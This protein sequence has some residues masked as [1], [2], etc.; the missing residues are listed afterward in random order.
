MDTPLVK[1]G[2]GHLDPEAPVPKLPLLAFA[3]LGIVF[4]DVG[5]SPLYTLKAIFSDT[6]V[7]VDATHASVLGVLSLIFWA[8][9]LVITIKYVTVVM[10]AQYEGEGGIFSMLASLQKVAV[11]RSSRWKSALVFMA[12]IL[13]AALLYGD[14]VITPAISVISAV[15]GLETISV[16][17]KHF[18]LPIAI[19]IIIG[20]FLWQRV[21]TDRIALVFSPIMLVWFLA[22]GFFGLLQIIEVP[23]ILQ[24]INPA[25]AVDFFMAHPAH[26]FFMLS[27]VVLCVTG[28]EA[29]YADLGQ[30]GRGA[31]TLAWFTVVWPCLLLNYF[32]QGAWI[33]SVAKEHPGGWVHQIKAVDVSHPFFSIIPDQMLWPMVIL[34]TVAAIIA[35]QAIITGVFAITRQA[36][37]L[38]LLPYIRIIYTS[39]E[40]INHVFLP[41]VNRFMLVG[42]IA[43]VLLFP[44]SNRLAAAYGVAVTA[45]MFTTTILLFVIGRLIWKWPYWAL[46]P[47]VLVFLIIDLAFFGANL[48]KVPDGGW[49]PLAIALIFLVLMST[50]FKGRTQIQRRH[51]EPVVKL[52]AFIEDVLAKQPTRIDGSGVFLTAYSN[53]TPSC[54]V[55]L[56]RHMPVLYQQS[57]IVSMQPAQVA[58]LPRSRQLEIQNLGNGFWLLIGHYGYLQTPN[59]PRLLQLAQK[60]GLEVDLKAIT[61]F[62]RR[63]IVVL[64]GS[65]RMLGW[66]KELFAAMSRNS[67]AM[68]EMFELPTGQVIEVGMRVDV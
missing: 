67:L 61:Y 4:G 7:G 34:A 68:S 57:I 65:T 44:S 48:M 40:R 43:A 60:H 45:V 23:V 18:I 53:T 26:A 25:W 63:E 58:R 51:Q 50:W 19:I 55:G 6:I 13:G 21:G 31:I 1:A 11:I 37:Q 9:A 33:L 15:E 14:G 35:S 52:D 59:V 2:A 66:R 24:A 30:F 62:T 5:T 10:R 49:F 27:L 42:C 16:E 29:L 22:I 64:G 17:M 39:H 38:R 36:I 41:A 3:S 28:A 32:G 20:L 46:V 12:A 47:M 56:Y 8:L 54:L